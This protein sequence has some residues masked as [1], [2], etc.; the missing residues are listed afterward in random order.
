M[1]VV[2]ADYNYRHEPQTFITAKLI[3]HAC[4]LQKDAIPQTLNMQNL[5]KG[6]SAKLFILEIYTR[7][8]V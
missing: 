2:F 5:S 1:F 8:T 4:M 7:Y 6:I 3:L